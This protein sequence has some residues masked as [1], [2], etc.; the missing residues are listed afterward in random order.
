M[1]L[2]VHCCSISDVASVNSWPSLAIYLSIGSVE[3]DRAEDYGWWRADQGRPGQESEVEL[4]AERS[5][6]L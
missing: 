5:S 2:C 1:V 6:A 4:R 3:A